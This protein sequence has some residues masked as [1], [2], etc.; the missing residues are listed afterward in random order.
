MKKIVHIV[1]TGTIDLY[2]TNRLAMKGWGVR[3][4]D[5]DVIEWGSRE[6]SLEVLNPRKKSRIVR[7]MIL[8]FKTDEESNAKNF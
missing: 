2:R 6:K 3:S 1:G 5:I 7:K 4:V 8:A